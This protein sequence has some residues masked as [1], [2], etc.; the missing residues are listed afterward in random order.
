MP[1]QLQRREATRRAVVDAA[2]ES[3]TAAGHAGVTLDDIAADAGVAK[4]TVLYHFGSRLG[5]LRAAAIELVLRV[6]RRIADRARGATASD[7][8]RA[9]LEGQLTASGRVLHRIGDE[10]AQ[11]RALDEGDPMAY[12]IGR[13]DDLGVEGEAEVVAAAILQFGRQLAYGQA[14]AA[15]IDAMVASLR[16]GGRLS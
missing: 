15:D 2:I 13:L 9:V 1:T 8:V 12:L 16:T 5:L 7:W 3:F 14:A 11:H 6:E 10:L 4:S